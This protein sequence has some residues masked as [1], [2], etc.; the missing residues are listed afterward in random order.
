MSEGDK[1]GV[2]VLGRRTG[3]VGAAAGVLTAGAAI[4]L[5]V[6]RFAVGRRRMPDPELDGEPFGSRRGTPLVVKT[7]DG[8]E[9]YAEVDELD[10]DVIPKQRRKKPPVTVVFSHGY[11]LNLDCWHFQRKELA[12][13]YRMAFYDQRSHG[14]SGR[15]PS[16]Q[17]NIPQLGRDLAAVLQEVAPEGPIVLVGHSMGG[18]TILALADQ[19][20]ELFAER[21]VG[22]CL[23]ATS[24]GGLDKVTLGVPGPVGRL[25]HRVAP[26]FVAALSRAPDL[27]EHGRKAGSDVG[28]LLTKH[29]S[30]GSKVPP[31]RV[32]F[33]AEMLAGTP[34]D[35][36]ADF[37]P[38]FAEHDKY[39]ALATLDG[40][41]ALIMCGQGDLI[42]P[43]EH[44]RELAWRL[45]NAEYVELEDCGHM[46][47]IEYPDEVNAHLRELLVRSK[48]VAGT[49]KRKSRR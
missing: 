3:L 24:A 41:E 17:T 33:V 7:D 2:G 29:Y 10:S 23:L 30:F 1:T 6:E 34:I 49:S 13:E 27:V 35:V 25:V 43:V 42:T 37:F 15:S 21:V 44:S 28:Y 38:G 47:L 31:A 32:E 39:H 4:G 20:P 40:I 12:G 22:V 48:A 26:A 8:L 19:Q 5:A 46:I 36:V 16:E 45:P 14:R 9:L 18:M 11:A